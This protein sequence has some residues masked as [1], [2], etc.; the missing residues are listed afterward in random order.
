MD[1]VPGT[2]DGIG[3]GGEG[4]SELLFHLWAGHLAATDVEVE[5]KEDASLLTSTSLNG[6][7]V[8]KETSSLTFTSMARINIKKDASFLDS[9]WWVE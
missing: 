2:T 8:E 1:E 6:T 9:E 4:G 7:E 5:V 3:G